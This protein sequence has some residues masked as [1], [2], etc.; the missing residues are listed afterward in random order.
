MARSNKEFGFFLRDSSNAVV[1]HNRAIRNC[2]G[3]GLINTGSPGGVHDWTLRKNRALRN[4]RRCPAGEG[5]PPDLRDWDRPPGGSH[6][7]LRDNLLKGNAPSGAAAFPGGIVVALSASLGGSNSAHNKIVHNRLRRNKPADLVWDGKGK[8]NRFD[9]NK[10]RKLPAER[11]LRLI[12]RV[13]STPR[14]RVATRRGLR[15]G[16]GSR[17]PPRSRSPDTWDPG[18]LF[19]QTT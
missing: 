5:G 4:T 14:W 17:A 7:V 18:R 6:N 2:L 12:R 15:L 3:M 9:H 11:P 13:P 8:G 19:D 16:G 1:T 10:C